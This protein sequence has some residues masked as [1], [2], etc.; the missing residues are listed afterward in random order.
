VAG[1]CL[2]AEVTPK[3][4]MLL[5]PHLRVPAV[6]LDL[7]VAPCTISICDY[8]LNQKATKEVDLP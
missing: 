5:E 2:N 1:A 3:P 6:C 8:S 7:A 4:R